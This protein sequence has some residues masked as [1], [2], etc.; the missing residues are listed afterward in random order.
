MLRLVKFKLEVRILEHYKLSRGILLRRKCLSQN[1]PLVLSSV[2]IN[3]MQPFV[4]LVRLSAVAGGLV[5]WITMERKKVN[6]NEFYLDGSEK[7][8]G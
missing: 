7:K 2:G 8:R 6:D 1:R 4:C 3:Y 5:D